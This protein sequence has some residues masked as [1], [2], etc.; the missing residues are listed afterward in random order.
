MKLLTWTPIIFSRKGFPRDE[1][2][3]P[4]LPKN[5]FEEAITSAVI[6]H[7]LKKDKALAHRVKQYLTTSGL[8]LDEVAKTVKRMV[9]EKYPVMDELK[10]PERVYLPED[11]IK[12]E[13]V[14]V[15]DLKEKV[16]V[17][18]FRTEVFKGSVEVPIESP[19]LDK[20]KAA[21]H[22][23][24]EALARMEKDLLEDHP[25]ALFFYEELLN[26]LKRWEIPLRLGM[27]TEVHFKGDLL[28]FWKIKEVR[29]FIMKEL[30]ID[31]RPRFVLYLPR[32]R[33]TSGWCELKTAEEV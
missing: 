33:A 30:G 29:D 10:L 11:R 4:F 21:A 23:F 5:A 7:H 14:E 27:W 28:F 9:L 31:I 13:F 24:A 15:F 26:E 1:E 12:E 2:G 17:K 3:K 32:E 25:L 8:K 22:S 6:F 19:H 20:L 18:G 16:N